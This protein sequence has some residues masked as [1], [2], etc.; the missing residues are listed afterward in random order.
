MEKELIE[1][2]IMRAISVGIGSVSVHLTKK[3]VTIE[4]A[5]QGLS[6]SVEIDNNVTKDAIQDV[7]HFGEAVM[8]EIKDYMEKKGK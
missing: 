7:R 1:K 5:T 2:A 8:G 4:F 3:S 6:I